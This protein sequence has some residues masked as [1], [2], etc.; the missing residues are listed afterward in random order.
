MTYLRTI[1]LKFGSNWAR[2][3]RRADF[4]RKWIFTGVL[5]L[6]KSHCGSHLGWRLG[7]SD[8][9][10]NRPKDIPSMFGQ[11]EKSSSRREDFFNG[12]IIIKI[13]LNHPP[14][15]IFSNGGQ[16]GKPIGTSDRTPKGI[17][18]RTIP[19]TNDGRTDWRRSQMMSSH[20]LSGQ[21]S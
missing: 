3:S 21:L 6:T 15:C 20:G 8:I 12:L 9:I 4:Y 18:P 16:I 14:F 7:S 13:F 17:Y 11:N 2:S 10:L 19:P 1:L 5:Y